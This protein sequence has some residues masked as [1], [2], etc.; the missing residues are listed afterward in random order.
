MQK[1]VGVVGTTPALGSLK[2]KR[3]ISHTSENKMRKGIFVGKINKQLKNE[4]N[5]DELLN[6]VN[7]TAW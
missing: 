1:T 3:L 7:L 2:V 5:L 6:N 4:I